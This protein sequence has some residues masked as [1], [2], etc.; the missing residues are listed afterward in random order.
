MRIEM[1]IR[2]KDIV[3]N[4]T[5]MRLLHKNGR[6]TTFTVNIS[7]LDI[8]S[9]VY[10]SNNVA[11][12]TTSTRNAA[13]TKPFSSS[14]FMTLNFYVTKKCKLQKMKYISKKFSL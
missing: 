4:S 5:K 11:G 13:E 2:L 9:N 3:Q 14:M 1:R 12:A 6:L 10:P 7:P 8:A